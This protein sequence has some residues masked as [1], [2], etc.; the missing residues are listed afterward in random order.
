MQKGFIGLVTI[1]TAS[2][3]ALLIGSSILFKSI[4]EATLS[5]DEELSAKAWATVSACGE[6]AVFSLASTSDNGVAVWNNYD[7]SETLT[8]DDYSCYYSITG[9]GTSTP[10]VIQAS[11]TVSDF[12][13]KLSI[14]VATNTPALDVTAWGEVADF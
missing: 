6:R 10:R 4:T 9:E 1:L 11:S 14:T 12:V 2:A 3:V 13:R 7:S 8:I 5:T